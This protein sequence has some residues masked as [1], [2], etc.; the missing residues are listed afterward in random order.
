MVTDRTR[1]AIQNYL[2]RHV[3]EKDGQKRRKKSLYAQKLYFY[4][5]IK[6]LYAKK[7]YIYVHI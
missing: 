7:P 6:S 2:V 4:V 5:R 1:D 3:I